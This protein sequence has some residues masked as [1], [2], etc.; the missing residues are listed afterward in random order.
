M[1]SV[2]LAGAGLD[3]A[4]PA[5]PGFGGG[6]EGLVARAAGGRWVSFRQQRFLSLP[7]TKVRAADLCWQS[8]PLNYSCD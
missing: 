4:A 8:R 6:S 1:F 3:R 5:P 7:V 2:V